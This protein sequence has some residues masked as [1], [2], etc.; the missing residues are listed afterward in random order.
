MYN[1]MGAL[2]MKDPNRIME[3]EFN[4]WLNKCPNNFVRL[5]SDKDSNTY[6]F[7]RNDVEED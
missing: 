3:D 4:D 6:R 2:K 5:E 7:Y 1:T